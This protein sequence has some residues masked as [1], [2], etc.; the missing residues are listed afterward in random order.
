MNILLFQS[1]TICYE[2]SQYFVKAFQTEL[3]ALGCQVALLDSQTPDQSI[4]DAIQN[5]GFPS[6]QGIL[7]FNS[8]LPKMQTPD[9]EYCLD[10]IDAPF[11]NYILDHP[12]YHHESLSVPLQNYHVLC[13]D[14][15]HKTYIEKYY[16]HIRSVHVLSLGGVINSTLLP[17]KERPYQLTFTGTYTSPALIE[18]TLR[19]EG[20]SAADLIFNL[21]AELKIHPHMTLEELV[22]TSLPGLSPQTFSGTMRMLFP[23]DMYIKAWFRHQVLVALLEAQIH[24]HVFGSGWQDFPLSGSPYF[25]YQ[26]EFLYEE[27]PKVMSQSQFVLNCNPWF[28]DGIHDRIFMALCNGAIPFSDPSTSMEAFFTHKKDIAFYQLHDLTQ[29]PVLFESLIKD[30]SNCLAMSLNAFKI[31]ASH[32]YANRGN[33]LL[34]ILRNLN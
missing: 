18:K 1:K 4:L 5:L 25:H 20:G 17:W 29:C 3:E 28:K 14:H 33:T 34:E 23:V 27:L 13:L 12:L 16:P 19:E 32:T 7:D 9:K 6:F 11:F 10:Q 21:A 22:T 8:T 31:G 2:S 15:H 30:T 26:G 24:L